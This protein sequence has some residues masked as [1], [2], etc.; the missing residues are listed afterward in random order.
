MKLNRVLIIFKNLHDV[1]KTTPD[2]EGAP[3][4]HEGTLTQIQD[5]LDELGVPNRVI[6]RDH[7]KKGFKGDLLITLGGDG[8]FLAASHIAGDIPVLGVNSMPGHSVG[9]FC[10]SN[11]SNFKD[12]ILD[13][14][15]GRLKLRKL[16][17]MEIS[18]DGKTLPFLALNDILFGRSSP[19]EMARYK[20][21]IGKRSEDQKS[22]GVW[23]STGAGS[24]G[25]ILSSGGKPMNIE[26]KSL[27]YRVREPYAHQAKKYK[28]LHGTITAGNTVEI[29]PERDAVVYN[30]G[31][32]VVYPVREGQ[33][34]SS[35]ISNK[36]LK[37]F[38]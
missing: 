15:K 8:T 18:I 22:S 9:Y 7:L 35:K 38:I 17:R 26:S 1:I 16:P 2:G 10:A 30:D 33:T 11:A 3:S 5:D 37:V 24:T 14:L 6:D 25:G 20:L 4:D 29:V 13:I 32:N 28:M 21:K 36:L 34:L 12:A 19:A 23:I 31:P 27:Q